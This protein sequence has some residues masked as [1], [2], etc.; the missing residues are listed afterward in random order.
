M[1]FQ[2]VHGIPPQS[3]VDQVL[4]IGKFDGVHI[5]HQAILD[6][7]RNV[8]PPGTRLAVMSFNPHPTFV[9]TGDEAYLRTLTPPTEKLRILAELGVGSYYSIRF[10]KAFAAMDPEQFVVEFGTRLRARQI[11]VGE[12][13]RFG[14]GGS[15]D[16]ALLRTVGSRLGIGVTVVSPVVEN[17]SKVSSSQIRAHLAA[18][19]VEAAE[20]LLGRPYT[21]TGTVVH[22]GDCGRAIGF[23]TANLSGIDAYVMPKSGVYAV[24]AAVSERDKGEIVSHEEIWFGVLLAGGRTTI[25]GDRFQLAVH[26]LGFSGDLYGKQCRVSFLRRIRDEQAF[27]SAEELQAQLAR[28]CDTTSAMVGLADV[29]LT[30]DLIRQG[31]AFVRTSFGKD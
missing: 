21:I 25:S 29:R 23:P 10:D 9:L 5:G 8:A 2:E 1:L 6:T 30:G 7:A 18:G 4:V 12:D 17:G 24:S 14:R 11:V 22:G 13:F 20:A 19:R 31:S 26:L 3:D 28:D 15:G 27:A 16:T